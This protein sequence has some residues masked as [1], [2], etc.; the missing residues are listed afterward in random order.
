MG[1]RVITSNKHGVLNKSE[2]FRKFTIYL[3]DSTFDKPTFIEFYSHNQ[4]GAKMLVSAWSIG[5]Q[6]MQGSQVKHSVL[7]CSP[8]TSCPS[9]LN[10][11]KIAYTSLSRAERIT[12]VHFPV[13]CNP[14]THFYE[15]AYNKLN[16]FGMKTPR[17]Y[18]RYCMSRSRDRHILAPLLIV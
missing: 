17:D 1:T 13:K 5:I 3:A 9:N 10:L 15:S 18:A 7:Y 8:N 11:R 2:Y 12:E 16:G 14:K 6:R 4:H